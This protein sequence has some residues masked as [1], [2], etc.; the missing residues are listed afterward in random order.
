[1]SR[2]NQNIAQSGPNITVG[3]DFGSTVNPDDLAIYQRDF[4]G[5]A[6]KHV[7][8][9]TVCADCGVVLQP[10]HDDCLTRA[11][12]EGRMTPRE[13]QIAR[14]DRHE[15]LDLS[16]IIDDAL[17]GTLQPPSQLRVSPG[18]LTK[19]IAPRDSM[20]PLTA[21]E[22]VYKGVPVIIDHKLADGEVHVIPAGRTSAAAR[23]DTSVG[24]A[25]YMA[26]LYSQFGLPN[27]SC[28]IKNIT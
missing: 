4:T 26:R 3:V 10:H 27:A 18:D 25:E 22:G 15:D 21:G 2:L 14:L 19:L 17:A 1:M 23:W 11:V 12:D 6:R 13:R 7:P 24:R 5:Y 16:R 20:V 8:D 9:G 28:V